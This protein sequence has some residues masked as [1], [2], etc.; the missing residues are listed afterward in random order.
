MMEDEAVLD[1]GQGSMVVGELEGV[2]LSSLANIIAGLEQT[3]SNDIIE[4][5]LT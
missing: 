5:D 3:R 2:D 1:L 4:L